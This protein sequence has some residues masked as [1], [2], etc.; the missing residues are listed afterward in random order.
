MSIF[1]V[2]KSD[3]DKILSLPKTINRDV[4]W[5]LKPNEAWAITTLPV[6]CQ[7]PG[8]LELRITV[9]TELPSKYSMSILLNQVRIKALDINGSHS[10]KC[11]DKKIWAGQTHKHDWSDVCPDGH[12][13]TPIDITGVTIET[14]LN[15]FCKE[16]N[17]VFKGTYLPVPMNP[18][19]TG[20]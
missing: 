2:T 17:I 20:V 1:N 4:R 13:Y 11:T 9:N 3:C 18:R 6:K 15:E 16:C 10:N 7:W 12:A 19:M 5:S 14:V 8:N